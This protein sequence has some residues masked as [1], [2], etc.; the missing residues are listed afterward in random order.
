MKVIATQGTLPIDGG[1]KLFLNRTSED[2]Q[3]MN[4]DSTEDALILPLPCLILT[5]FQ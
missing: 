2:E 4:E 5:S 1:T 3:T